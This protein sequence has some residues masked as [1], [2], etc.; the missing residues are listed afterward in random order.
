[1]EVFIREPKNTFK[2]IKIYKKLTKKQVKE[3]KKQG[4][5]LSQL[6][7]DI[8]KNIIGFLDNKNKVMFSTICKHFFNVFWTRIQKQV[9]V[10][11]FDKF[12]DWYSNDK[13]ITSIKFNRAFEENINDRISECKTVEMITL[14]KYNEFLVVP[15]NIK[16]VRMFWSISPVIKSKSCVVEYGDFY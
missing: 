6:N 9:Y 5:L 3:F 11:N 12:M 10:K 4:K 13:M 15:N 16:K 2:Y 14:G 8:I 1:M 7:E